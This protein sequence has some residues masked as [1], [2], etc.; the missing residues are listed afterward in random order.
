MVCSLFL[1]CAVLLAPHGASAHEVYVLSPA[2]IAQDL[3]S[4]SPN[5]FNAFT[6]HKAQ[7]FLW[8][9]IAF[10]VVSTVFFASITHTVEEFFAPYFATMRKWGTC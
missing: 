1:V 8:A 5:P 4:P 9:F 2:T 3:S 6:D 10:V 7:F